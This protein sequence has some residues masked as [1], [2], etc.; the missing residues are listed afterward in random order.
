MKLCGAHC[1]VGVFAGCPLSSETRCGPVC[2]GLM[3][4]FPPPAPELRHPLARHNETG[5]RREREGGGEEEEMRTELGGEKETHTISNN[6][7]SHFHNSTFLNKLSGL[8][9]QTIL[10][11]PS[12]PFFI[13]VLI[14][15]CPGPQLRECPV[16]SRMRKQSCGLC[17]RWGEVG[18][19]RP[20]R[21]QPG[22]LQQ[23]PLDGSREPRC[24]DERQ[25]PSVQPTTYTISAP[26]R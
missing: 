14:H 23:P 9:H 2:P 21:A 25:G 17:E 26:V 24:S 5:K 19:R 16:V 4:E 15:L 12:R 20:H 8:S 6:Q 3:G 18:L 22:E 10:P 7:I 11:G 13:C 1:W